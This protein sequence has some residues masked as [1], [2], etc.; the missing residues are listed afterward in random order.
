MG[1]RLYKGIFFSFFL[2]ASIFFIS[3]GGGGGGDDVVDDGEFQGD[4]G[5]GADG[6]TI[7]WQYYTGNNFGGGN[8]A[9]EDGS[10][11]MAGTR[12]PEL[13][14]Q[15]VYLFKTDDEGTLD[16]EEP[17]PLSGL[18]GA[19]VVRK[20]GDGGYLVAGT[21]YKPGDDNGDFLL[22]KTDVSG[23]QSWMTTWDNGW[24]QEGQSVWPAAGGG[25][26]FLGNSFVNHPVNIWDWDACTYSIDNSG[27]WAGTVEC[28]GGAD[29]HE[30]AFA[31]EETGDGGYI[32]AGARGVIE[33]NFWLVKTDAGGHMEKGW[34]RTYESGTAYS[35]RAL[36]DGGFIMAGKN[37]QP[38]EGA[39][40]DVLV[41]R[42][43]PLG[44]QL[45]S[46]TFGGAGF[47]CANG[48]ALAG[49]D[50]VLIAGQ[51]NSF[52]THTDGEAYPMLYLIKLDLDGNVLWQKIKGI[53]DNSEMANSIREVSDGGFIIAAG[54]GDILVKTDK[55]GGTVKLGTKDVSLTI[56]GV[57]GLID[58]T[59]AVEGAGGGVQSVML[60]WNIGYQG[61]EWI[62]QVMDEG[63]ESICDS[64][65]FDISPDPSGGVAEGDEYVLTFADCETTQ[66]DTVIFSG[67]LTV[68]FNTLTGTFSPS[69]QYAVETEMTT[70]GFDAEDDIGTLTITGSLRFDR[71]V[72]PGGIS[73]TAQN[74]PS[75]TL[76]FSEGGMDTTLSEFLI[77][78]TGGPA[79]GLVLGSSGET[80][81]YSHSSSALD[82]DMVLEIEEALVFGPWLEDPSGAFTVTAEDDSNL[83]VTLDDGSVILAVD[84]D[85]DGSTDGTIGTSWEELY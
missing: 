21:D 11:I 38:F 27:A 67:S 52:H 62:L 44:N 46:K 5:I 17:Y 54:Y 1:W 16:W 30:W 57:T 9:L 4:V 53:A 40:A 37:A 33:S 69:T 81:V 35:V 56:P 22:I 18:E 20:T 15:D 75:E 60:P 14:E 26:I 36:D 66:G 82:A 61:L 19:K 77:N 59:N 55:N 50:A 23:N 85:G 2:L 64:G 29:M 31:M 6:V 70:A 48:I 72:S 80:V 43:D 71:T 49:T 8:F 84:T 58:F 74:V 12:G 68:D 76:S 83:A 24:S 63:R 47:D 7:F 65:S 13:G 45:W 32:I 78:A 39:T 3:C 42:T 10:F 28:F 73:E 79:S 34:P 51:T 25:Y 41:I